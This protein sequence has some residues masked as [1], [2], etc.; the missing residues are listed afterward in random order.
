MTSDAA[1]PARAT[2][3]PGESL[4]S[5]PVG[6]GSGTTRQLLTHP[7]PGSAFHM[8]RFI[9]EPGGGMPRHTNTVEHQQ[10][11]LRGQAVIGLGDEEVEVKAGDVLHIPAGL[12][13]WYR[14]Q[15][16]E[17]FEFLCAV[18]NAP[19]ELRILGEAEEPEC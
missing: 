3:T 5:R 8:R 10:L 19:D 11:V 4:E 16:S 9:M 7:N 13:H 14:A 1:L 17:P 2:V 12:P 15:G 18:P 6:A